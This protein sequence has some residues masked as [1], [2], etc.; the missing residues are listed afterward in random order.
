MKSTHQK[1][2]AAFTLIELLVVIAIISILAGMLLPAL[3]RAKAK[4]QR[5]ACINNLHQIGLGLVMWCDDNEN[6]YPWQVPHAE[7]G[8]YGNVYGDYAWKQFLAL[9]N[10]VLNPKL[11]ACMSDSSKSPV[12]QFSS[13]ANNKC[14]SYSVGVGAT[15]GH[16][17]SIL[18]TDGN[19]T[20]SG[21]NSGITAWGPAGLTNPPAT[22][23]TFLTNG[24][25]WDSSIHVYSG[26]VLLGDGS[27]HQ[28]TQ[29]G[30]RRQVGAVGGG[31]ADPY[32]VLLPVL[33]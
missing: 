10:Y 17:F 29:A 18:A 11:L 22:G 20:P 4:G 28:L 13:I 1:K 6:K 19:I 23:L 31:V 12:Y 15:P 14:I 21:L 7:D 24:S 30:L 9:S 2:S 8:T 5:I 33:K 25:T 27:S 32:V 3:A 16:P 26:N